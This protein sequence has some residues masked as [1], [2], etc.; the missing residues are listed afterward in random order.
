MTKR[1]FSILL[2]LLGGLLLGLLGA[3]GCVVYDDALRRE[4]SD[5]ASDVRRD[6]VL[7]L[8][9][10]TGDGPSGADAAASDVEASRDA[11]V[12]PGAI[13]DATPIEDAR[14]ESDA[15]A[16]LDAAD[17]TFEPRI[18]GPAGAGEDAR[19]D[20]IGDAGPD[21]LDASRD[22]PFDVPGDPPITGCTV[23]FTVSG[24]TWDE[25][26]PANDS[27]GRAVRL[28]GDISALGAWEPALGW[29]MNE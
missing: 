14:D 20:A 26:G 12:E 9:D 29:P 8:R 11:T 23:D 22:A 17:V 21:D 16:V 19:A 25:A 24:V 6:S 15:N 28:V 27:G 2:G 5:A 1:Q 4:T 7:L 18:D 3:T 13:E 10:G